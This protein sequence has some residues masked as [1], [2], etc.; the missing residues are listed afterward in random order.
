[1]GGELTPDDIRHW[2]P[3][4]INQL[5]NA[6]TRITVAHQTLGDSLGMAVARTQWDGGSGDAFRAAMGATRADIDADADESTR[7]GL[8]IHGAQDGVTWC[9]ASIRAIDDGA[10]VF[11]WTVGEDWQIN[12]GGAD[13]DDFEEDWRQSL[14]TDL[15]DLKFRANAT[16]TEL[17][18]G[19][20]AAMGGAP[21]D[22]P[23][24]HQSPVPALPD[25]PEQF[26][27]AWNALSREQKEAE[28]QQNP[29]IG[30]HPGMPFEDKTIFNERHLDQLTHDTQA[31]VDAMQARYDQ[32]ARQVYMGDHSAETGNQLAA[33]GP[34]LQAAKHSLAEYH[35]AQNAMKAPPGSPK[36]YRGVPRRQGARGGLYR[37][38]RQGNPQRHP[39]SRHR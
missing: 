29:F 25:D 24:D 36:R 31:N 37:Q 2:D 15:D 7:V 13:L 34:R 23:G 10:A 22:A 35:G 21:L 17:A 27:K 28:Y 14:Q 1:L 5:F 33:L 3:S 32:L 9:R 19:V 38:S 4:I 8:A 18:T 30:N 39:C 11:G 26:S 20:R 16:D 6:S 12:T